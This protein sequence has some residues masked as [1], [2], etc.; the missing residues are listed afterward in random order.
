[1]AT[2]AD[3]VIGSLLLIGAGGHAQSCIDVIEREGRFVIAGLVGLP[4]EVGNSVLG[5]RVIG[6]D[7]DLPTLR[8]RHEFALVTIG[9]IKTA[10]PR[11]AAYAQLLALGFALPALVSPGAWVS[12]HAHVGAGSIVMHGAVVNAGAVVGDNCIINS[13]ALVEHG[14]VIGSHCH[15]ATGALVNGDVTIGERTFIGSGA[16][17]REGLV[18]GNDCVIGMGTLV[19]SG[20][21]DGA[22]LPANGASA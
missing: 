16:V 7:A 5:Y 9:Q 12:P 1:M 20:C 19:H 22:R 15:I 10:T 18:I 13:R 6:S 2:A 21:G 11:I 3:G 14:T 17:I 4:H 8:Q